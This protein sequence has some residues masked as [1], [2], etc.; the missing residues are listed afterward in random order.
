MDNR[1]YE[2]HKAT[3]PV[4]PRLERVESSP[5]PELGTVEITVIAVIVAL[6]VYAVW[7]IIRDIVK[8]SSHTDKS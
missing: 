7:H 5:T 2:Q 4:T 1:A 6:A 8:K 3:Q